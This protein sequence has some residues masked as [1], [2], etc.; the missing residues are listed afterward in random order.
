[1]SFWWRNNCKKGFL[2]LPL[3]PKH[4]SRFMKYKS[5]PECNPHYISVI[6]VYLYHI[7]NKHQICYVSFIK[8]TVNSKC[9]VL[10]TKKEIIYSLSLKGSTIVYNVLF[11]HLPS[12]SSLFTPSVCECVCLCTCTHTH[13]HWYVFVCLELYM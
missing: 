7:I 13:A 11:Y 10:G 3:F 5:N 6:I 4:Y 12:S 2:C 8:H 1:M 9:W